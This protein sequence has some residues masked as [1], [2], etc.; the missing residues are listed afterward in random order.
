MQLS[1]VPDLAHTRP[2]AMHWL[3]TATVMVGVVGLAGLLQP[4]DGAPR[5]GHGV[6]TATTR[7]HAPFPAPGTAGVDFPLEC[8]GVGSVVTE[9]ASGDLDGDGNPET[10]AV[11][12]CDGGSGTPPSAVYVLT[13]GTGSGASA[14]PPARIVATLVTPG[15]KESVGEGFGIKGGVVLATL[16]GYS[17]PDVPRCC[18]DEKERVSWQWR[19]GAFVRSDL[20]DGR[21]V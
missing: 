11:V 3:A 14:A 4:G 6:A 10:V 20:A 7:D 13:R 19:N 8:G 1:D 15:D 17:T 16:L 9:K 18:P 21:S 12:R 2:H 5:S